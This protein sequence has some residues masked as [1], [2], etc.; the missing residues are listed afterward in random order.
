MASVVSG[1][2]S[3]YFGAKEKKDAAELAAKKRQEDL[4]LRMA[5]QN[6][7]LTGQANEA[8]KNIN[9]FM[10]SDE[11][12]P[13]RLGE[14]M[15]MAGQFDNAYGDVYNFSA[16]DHVLKT[17]KIGGEK[18]PGA[19]GP[20]APN[21]VGPDEVSNPNA[22]WVSKAQRNKAENA[23]KERAQEGN[24]YTL[25]ERGMNYLRTNASTPDGI[26]DPQK[27]AWALLNWE[28][29][30]MAT[31]NYD[32]EDMMK[33]TSAMRKNMGDVIDG[34]MLDDPNSAA[35]KE[36]IRQL[37]KDTSAWIKSQLGVASQ[38]VNGEMVF[39][40]GESSQPLANQLEAWGQ[41]MAAIGTSL[42]VIKMKLQEAFMYDGH[43]KKGVEGGGK[44]RPYDEMISKMMTKYPMAP[45][46]IQEA[47][48]AGI[49]PVFWEPIYNESTGELSLGNFSTGE[50]IP[51]YGGYSQAPEIP[52]A[53][54][55]ERTQAQT[56]DK[57]EQEKPATKTEKK[58]RKQVDFSV[59]A[60]PG[61]IKELMR[62][63]KEMDLK[64]RGKWNWETGEPK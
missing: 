10:E 61:Q 1:F 13:G 24:L 45:A 7:T 21:G 60:A 36:Q 9:A 46:L 51:L 42:P 43:W 20:P 54:V 22:G 5:S 34:M 56:A 12:N 58:P 59:G 38:G 30:E 50:M 64:A 19:Q 23:A 39:S 14:V 27:A 11:W 4:A 8:F 33:V 41:E 3:S 49:N 55:E 37:S 26:L 16:R 48:D 62:K 29:E 28:T 52:G 35:N 47:Y 17:L 25:Q 53:T 44:I 31:G 18:R 6:T 57:V 63:S 2:A 32:I 15:R 40:L